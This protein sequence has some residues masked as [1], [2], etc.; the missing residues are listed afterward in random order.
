MAQI[1][2]FDAIPVPVAHRYE[3]RKVGTAWRVLVMPSNGA[4]PFMYDSG[5]YSEDQA[6]EIA[7]TRNLEPRS[8]NGSK[9]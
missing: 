1:I 3:A 5:T 7:R 8:E 2:M 4:R 9:V 6:K